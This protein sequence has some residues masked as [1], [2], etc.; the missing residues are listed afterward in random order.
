[1]IGSPLPKRGL[2]GAALQLVQTASHVIELKQC[3]FDYPRKIPLSAPVRGLCFE[4][5]LDGGSHF[6]AMN[7]EFQK[8]VAFWPR[9]A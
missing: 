5:D 7:C 4:F 3:D 8:Q 9:V 1:M 2:S 6:S